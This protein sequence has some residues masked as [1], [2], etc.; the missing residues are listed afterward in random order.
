[1]YE[2]AINQVYLLCSFDAMGYDGQP[3]ATSGVNG[4]SDYDGTQS[5]H[6]IRIRI[7]WCK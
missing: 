3:S 2:C 5:F 4:G 7:Y 1:M 6:H